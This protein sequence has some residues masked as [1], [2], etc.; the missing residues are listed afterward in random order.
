MN[1]RVARVCALVSLALVFAIHTHFSPHRQLLLFV[2]AGT[3]D[4]S[5]HLDADTSARCWRAVQLFRQAHLATPGIN[6]RTL[7]SGGVDPAGKTLHNFNPTTTPHWRYVT[8]ELKRFG[9]VSED[10][11]SPGIPAL[12]TVHE[13][14]MVHDY[15]AAMPTRTL[16]DVVV[17]VT[18]FHTNRVRHLFSVAF[19]SPELSH[20]SANLKFEEV[21][22]KVGGDWLN[23]RTRHEAAALHQLSTHPSGP[24][25]AFVSRHGLQ[26]ANLG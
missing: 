9:M 11:I 12:Y 6:A 25:E 23:N 26:A 14:L 15:L 20:V 24:W 2:V 18:A 22:N 5:G 8:A 21:P 4:R 19:Q 3:N 13:A 16:I 17:V 7:T 1:K 10:I